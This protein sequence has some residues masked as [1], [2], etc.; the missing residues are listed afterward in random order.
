M[1]AHARRAIATRID[2]PRPDPHFLET[3]QL[4][5]FIVAPACVTSERDDNFSPVVGAAMQIRTIL[6]LTD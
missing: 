2:D 3:A 4:L 1:V 6:V 5:A